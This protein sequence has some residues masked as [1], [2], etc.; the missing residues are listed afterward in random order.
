[1]GRS[2]E[3]A[4]GLRSGFSGEWREVSDDR[5]GCGV[6]RQGHTFCTVCSLGP[7]VNLPLLPLSEGR[8]GAEEVEPQIDIPMEVKTICLCQRLECGLFKLQ[9]ALFIKMVS[10][11]DFVTL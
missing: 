8:M 7:R 6:G 10:R 11:A 2:L 5:V 4:L 3:G 9:T 1:M